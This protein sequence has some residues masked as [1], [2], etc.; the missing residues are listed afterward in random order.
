M[1]PNAATIYQ[2]DLPLWAQ[3]P[4]KPTEY[5]ILL[6]NLAAKGVTAV[7]LRPAVKN[8]R[9]RGPVFYMHDYAL[10]IPGRARRL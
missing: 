10:D 7:D 9:T 4:G 6:A 5:D 3:N 2:D 1:P 8:A